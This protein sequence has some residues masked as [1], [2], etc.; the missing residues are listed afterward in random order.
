M[1][2]RLLGLALCFFVLPAF[3]QT[4]LSG[5]L[6]KVSVIDKQINLN[7]ADIKTLSKSIK[8]IGSKRAEAIITYRQKHG[9][10]KSVTDLA[11]VPGLGQKFVNSHADELQRIFIVE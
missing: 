6:S 7:T 5:N 4:S 1:K 2:R 9:N 8:G 11:H 3:S 10:F